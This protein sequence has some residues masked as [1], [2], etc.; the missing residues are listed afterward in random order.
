MD[1]NLIQAFVEIVDAGT[2]AEAGRRRGVTR[3]QVSRQLRELE[4]QAGA[5]LLRRTT[6]R[7]ELTEPGQ[8]LYGHGLRIVGELASAR[9]EIDSLGTTLR[10]HLRVS[11]PTGLGESFVAPLL[12]EFA[13]AHP[14]ITLRVLFSNRIDDLIA[15]EIDVALKATAQPPLDQ[16]AREICA[17]DWQLCAAPAY[18]DRVAAQRGALAA[19]QDLADCDFICA[20]T[21][22]NPGRRHVL[23]LERAGNQETVPLQP[24][25]Q[26][27]H[28]PFLKRA[29]CEG[30]GIGL[31]PAY[32]AWDALTDGRLRQILP[33]WKPVGQS[34][35]LYVLTSPSPHVS[36]ATR[37]LI[38]FLRERIPRLD[39]FSDKGPAS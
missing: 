31:L 37:A 2:L 35:R 12:L 22:A 20:P 27:E 32:V 4:T 5:Q 11:V 24:H 1:L 17:I 26:S 8:T 19:P 25:L 38:A 6:R 29:I 23:T 13:A 28:F 3:S 18:L 16:V 15:A 36:I 14:A 30:H 10:G 39:V 34:D 9:A 33:D 21:A 7:L